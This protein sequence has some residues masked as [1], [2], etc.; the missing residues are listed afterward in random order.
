MLIIGNDIINHVVMEQLILI[1]NNFDNRNYQKINELDQENFYNR[2]SIS[3][4]ELKIYY[5]KLF[6]F[7]DEN[8]S[9]GKLNIIDYSKP[10]SWINKITTETNKNDNFHKD[11]SHLTAIT[12]LN[13]DF[14]GGEFTYI[15]ENEIQQK[16]KP[17]L[18]QTLVMDDNLLHK[19][20]P[21]TNGNRFS[22]VTFFQFRTKKI[23][24]LL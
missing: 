14:D 16:I 20:S 3:N 17:K 4:D 21:V 9:Y 7:L 18:N 6:L 24:S 1:C 15:D 5:D 19:V 2:V 10:N 8:I 12:Y 23:K 13:D 22:L 11:R